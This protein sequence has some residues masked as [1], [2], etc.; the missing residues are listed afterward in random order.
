[1][2]GE[3]YT[4]MELTHPFKSGTGDYINIGLKEGNK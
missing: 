1:M 3:T 4:V 2:L